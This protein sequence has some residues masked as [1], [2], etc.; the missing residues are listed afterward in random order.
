MDKLGVPGAKGDDNKKKGRSNTEA[1]IEE[2]E[3]KKEVYEF[4]DE[5]DDF[6]EFELGEQQRKGDVDMDAPV[7]AKGLWQ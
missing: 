5:D 2:N 4:L 1:I 3:Q 6:E 7:P